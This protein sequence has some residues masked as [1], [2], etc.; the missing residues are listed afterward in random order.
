MPDY[1]I[2]CDAIRNNTLIRDIESFSKDQLE[3]F[4]PYLWSL[5]CISGTG[6]SSDLVSP[7]RDFHILISSLQ[8]KI[9]SRYIDFAVGN[10]FEKYFQFDLVPVEKELSLFREQPSLFLN[11]DVHFPNM[12]EKDKLL[13]IGKQLL[14]ISKLMFYSR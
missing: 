9:R 7:F 13:Y 10:Q 2:V 8:D 3:P 1:T 4:L 14:I 5:T 11:N 12:S 6:S